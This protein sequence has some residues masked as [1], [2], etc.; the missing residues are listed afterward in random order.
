MDLALHLVL[1]MSIEILLMVKIIN[2]YMSIIR[3]LYHFQLQ[4]NYN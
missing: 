3:V 1:D 4:A 2:H